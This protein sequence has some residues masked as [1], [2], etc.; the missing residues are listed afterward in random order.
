MSTLKETQNDAHR[1]KDKQ[2]KK[3][4]S[5]VD[6]LTGEINK[7]K[8]QIDNM[9]NTIIEKSKQ[10]AVLKAVE[11]GPKLNNVPHFLNIAFLFQSILF[12][13]NHSNKKG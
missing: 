1:Q 7:Y 9:N 10:I 5:E 8:C 12:P 2:I 11:G 4:K 13:G 6:N 3:L